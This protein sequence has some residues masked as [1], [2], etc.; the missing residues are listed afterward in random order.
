MRQGRRVRLQAGLPARNDQ[1]GAGKQ[2]G[3]RIHQ[4]TGQPGLEHCAQRQGQVV[5]DQGDGQR[6]NAGQRRHAP[7]SRT[8]APDGGHEAECERDQQH[9]I[10]QR[11]QTAGCRLALGEDPAI[12]QLRAEVGIDI[13][14]HAEI[15][16]RIARHGIGQ[17]Q[18]E[19][20]GPT[21]VPGAE[22][23][24]AALGN[25]PRRRRRQE[26]R[27]AIHWRTLQADIP[28]FPGFPSRHVGLQAEPDDP[29]GARRRRH[30]PVERREEARLIASA[31]D[32]GQRHIGRRGRRSD[33][34][35]HAAAREIDPRGRRHRDGDQQ[36]Q[37]DGGEG[38]RGQTHVH[39]VGSGQADTHCSGRS[40]GIDGL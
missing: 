4:A 15:D 10:D 28:A 31:E 29:V 16:R 19:A 7:A 35:G 37:G 27:N 25:L 14:F 38:Q 12:D 13:A 2:D 11:K 23:E 24:I 9:A 6:R 26:D 5:V 32:I 18:D 3:G 22:A 39:A 34:Q 36:Q 20:I 1:Q 40:A 8:G 33:L 21:R 30:R 17:G